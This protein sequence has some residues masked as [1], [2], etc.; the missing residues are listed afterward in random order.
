ME[1]VTIENAALT[2]A[3]MLPAI[4]TNTMQANND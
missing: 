4:C 3:V 2:L 1:L